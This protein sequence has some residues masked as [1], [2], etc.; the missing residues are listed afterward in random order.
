LQPAVD[1]VS[2]DENFRSDIGTVTS[3]VRNLPA[4][5]PQQFLHRV[6][7]MRPS[8]TYLPGILNKHSANKR[9]ATDADV[10]QADIS[11]LQTFYMN[12]FYTGIQVLVTG[13]DR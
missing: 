5:V 11:M 12:F 4:V 1:Q 13:W 6:G 2:G 9:F 10:K 7:S 8:F 3:A